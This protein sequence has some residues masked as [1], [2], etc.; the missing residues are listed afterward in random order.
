MMDVPK[1]TKEQAAILGC[2]TGISCGPFGDVQELAEEVLKR[3]IF[4]HEFA[5]KDVWAKL[6]EAVRDRFIALCHGEGK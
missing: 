5:N 6:R 1:L 4:T 3:P 2:Y